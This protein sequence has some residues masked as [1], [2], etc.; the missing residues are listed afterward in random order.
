MLF[1]VTDQNL[2]V[3]HKHSGQFVPTMIMCRFLNCVCSYKQKTEHLKEA[4]SHKK[5]SRVRPISRETEY[6]LER[7]HEQWREM[8]GGRESQDDLSC[9]KCFKLTYII[10]FS[11]TETV[12][13]MNLS[14]KNTR[15]LKNDSL[16]SRSRKQLSNKD[17]L[18]LHFPVSLQS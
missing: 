16:E 14:S 6:P 4:P 8:G 18:F 17:I 15:I 10:T 7:V 9:T 11:Q 5:W 13:Q 2:N 1:G 12:W 3:T